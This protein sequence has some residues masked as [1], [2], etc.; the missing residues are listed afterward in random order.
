MVVT[1]AVATGP[2]N[3]AAYHPL[4]SSSRKNIPKFLGDGKVTTDEHIRKFFIAINVLGVNHEDVAVWLFVET[5]TEVAA[6]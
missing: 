3:F 5:L 6:A 2:L 4:P 1:W